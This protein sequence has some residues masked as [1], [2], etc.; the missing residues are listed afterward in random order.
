[1]SNAKWKHLMARFMNRK[2]L[3]EAGLQKKPKGYEA[4]SN[5]WILV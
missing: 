2:E 4:V 3:Y 1:M 5:T